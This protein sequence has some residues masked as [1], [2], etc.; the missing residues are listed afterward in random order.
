MGWIRLSEG[1]ENTVISERTI[2]NGL[3]STFH[4]YLTCAALEQRADNSSSSYIRSV[5]AGKVMAV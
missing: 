5:R 3:P 2:C 4:C 1:V